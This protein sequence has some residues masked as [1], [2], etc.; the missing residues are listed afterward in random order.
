MKKNKSAAP[1][2]DPACPAEWISHSIDPAALR[3]LSMRE[4]WALRE[5]IRTMF[6]VLSGITCQPRFNE[7]T[8]D[9]ICETN[10]AGDLLE[11]L[12]DW[13]GGY[14]QAIVNIAKE[15]KPKAGNDAEWRGHLMVGYHAD[16][17]DSLAEI[18]TLAATA[19]RDEVR[20]RFHD[21]HA[22]T[23]A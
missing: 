11:K 9:G 8:R 14:E 22:R 19:S 6:D 18:S 15:A 20:A 13:L 5:G 3:N 7:E 17:N 23:A 2:N 12:N 10:K 16:L 21:N 4:L 1:T